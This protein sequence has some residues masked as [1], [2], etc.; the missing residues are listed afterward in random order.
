MITEQE[1]YIEDHSLGQYP[2]VV[3]AIAFDMDTAAMEVTYP[4]DSWR[5]GYKEIEEILG[6]Y[7]FDRQ[8]RSV[9]YGNEKINVVATIVAVRAL[10]NT[11]PWF[12]DSVKDIRILQ[13]LGNDDLRPLL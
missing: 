5:N 9:Y 6:E 7:G 10:S 13:L 8:Q 11:L 4:G 1:T 12:K 2:V 3:Y